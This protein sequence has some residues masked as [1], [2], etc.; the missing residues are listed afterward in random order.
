MFLGPA[1]ALISLA[2]D[3]Y[4]AQQEQQRENK[5]ADIRSDIT[6]QFQAIAKDLENQIEL[7]LQEFEQQVYGEIEQQIATGRQQEENA[8]AA[9]NTWVKELLEVRKNFDLI[10]RYITKVTENLVI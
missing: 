9:S 7:Q 5:I 10:L 3:A 8:I 6:S 2:T 4:T 1:V